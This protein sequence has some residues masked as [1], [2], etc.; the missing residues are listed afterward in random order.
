[1]AA[2]ADQGLRKKALDLR[3]T[4]EAAL[5]HVE[6]LDAL[7]LEA[8]ARAIRAEGMLATKDKRIEMLEGALQEANQRQTRV[9]EQLQQTQAE[10]QRAA[11]ELEAVAARVAR[12]SLERDQ[13]V[14]AQTALQRQIDDLLATLED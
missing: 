13:A 5:E 1:M 8:E 4:L 10:Q 3:G 12:L 11:T 7:R 14:Q 6:Q 9:G 2:T